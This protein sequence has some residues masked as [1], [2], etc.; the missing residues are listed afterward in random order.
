M[1]TSARLIAVAFAM[2]VPAFTQASGNHDS[3]A[4]SVVGVR[5]VSDAGE[6]RGTAVLIRREDLAAG[7]RLHFLTSARLIPPEFD[8]RRV[9]T[10]I[11]LVLDGTRVL[12]V[13]TEDVFVTG[14]RFTEVAILEATGT[15]LP[16]LQPWPVVYAPPP[17]GADFLLLGF[18]NAGGVKTVAERVR[19]ESTLLAVG[20]RDAS[21]LAGCVGAP[22][23]APE[24][25]FGVVRDCESGRSPTISLMSV[26]RSFMERHV[27][28]H[29]TQ[30]SDGDKR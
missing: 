28:P 11:Q 24:G 13:K 30:T 15:A 21:A 4:R 25:V 18:D 16:P 22:A 1:K 5:V 27:P 2:L 10:R 17:V 3:S 19:F 9:P 14:N 20:D 8:H 6:M 12:E 29:T 7:S 23:I 26:A